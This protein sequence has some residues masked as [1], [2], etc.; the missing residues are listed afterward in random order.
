MQWK[1]HCATEC[2]LWL[3]QNQ[4][5]K[6]NLTPLR[7][8]AASNGTRNPTS[9]FLPSSQ[10]PAGRR[11][12]LVRQIQLSAKL[13]TLPPLSH[14]NNI[15]ILIFWVCY[16]MSGMSPNLMLQMYLPCMR[17]HTASSQLLPLPN[18][19]QCTPPFDATRPQEQNYQNG[20][21]ARLNSWLALKSDQW[22]FYMQD[23][24]PCPENP[25]GVL[26][27]RFSCVWSP[28]AWM[29]AAQQWQTLCGRQVQPSRSVSVSCS[30]SLS[31]S[32]IF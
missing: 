9:P 31:L 3:K 22:S 28:R 8:L 11:E 23:I 19:P 7:I 6:L 30:R 16:G 32:R 4:E 2:P 18:A 13:L 20:R 12:V 5:N 21:G 29:P 25:Q 10:H 26:A 24:T 1:C 14:H 15:M 27:S 17:I